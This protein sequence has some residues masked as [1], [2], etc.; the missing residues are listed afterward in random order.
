M[1]SNYYYLVAGLPDLVFDEGKTFASSDAFIS[2]AQEQL[3]PKDLQLF[4][5]VRYPFD[6]TNLIAL[7]EK[8]ALPHD[9][10]GTFCAEELS[11]ALKNPDMLPEYMQFFL[12]DH[13]ENRSS[14]PGMTLTDQLNWF[15]YT[16]A[17]HHTN[18][19]IA[20]WFTFEQNLRNV[21]SGINAQKGLSHLAVQ[22]TEREKAVAAF[23]V[24]RDEVAEAVLRSSSPDFGLGTQYPWVE[25]LLGFSRGNLTDLEKGIDT[26]RWDMLNEM[27]IFSY[28][29][30]ETILA[31]FIKL[32]IVERWQGL[33][34]QQGRKHLDRLVDELKSS[35]SVPAGF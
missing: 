15:F 21:A 1:A 7:L 18:P 4:A 33:D 28:F 2:E 31:F 26:L 23:I 35:Y 16:W 10:R 25:K 13:R 22:A 8:K 24:G 9:A 32:S 6:N 17:M 3:Q 27:T 11:L 29:Q 14:Q 19:F 20:G 34:E 5:A 30:V 12:E